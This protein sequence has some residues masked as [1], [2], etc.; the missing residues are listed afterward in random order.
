MVT[1]IYV[2]SMLVNW[3]NALGCQSDVQQCW[4]WGARTKKCTCNVIWCIC[5]CDIILRVATLSMKACGDCL[6]PSRS[7]F[8]PAIVL[9]TRRYNTIKLDQPENN[10][11]SQLKC[12][13][14]F[15]YICCIRMSASFCLNKKKEDTT[16]LK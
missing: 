10:L 1:L 2:A 6:V 14:W 4:R 9:W 3:S 11:M 15:L 13:I 12:Y 16:N 8:T 5:Y 7:C